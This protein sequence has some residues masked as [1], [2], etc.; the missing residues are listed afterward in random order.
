MI[1]LTA[2]G[3]TCFTLETDEHSLIFDPWLSENPEAAISPEEVSAD[4][5]L[6]SHGHSD[7][8]G[9]AIE[10]A[11]RLDVPILGA[12]ELC[13][14]CQRHGVAVEPMHIGGGRQFEF[15]HVRLTTATHGSAVI[16]D[17]LVEYTGPACGFVVSA[18][19]RVVYYA[20]DTGLFGDMALIGE[21]I[22]IDVAILPIGDN[23][24]MGPDDAVRAAQML[25]PKVVVPMHY[26]AF[27]II[28][29]DP[30]QFADR[31]AAL[32]INCTVLA[33]GEY[34]ELD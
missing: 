1:K 4:A 13:M 19:G 5:I 9:D 34:T 6:V 31:L 33:P 23:F 10:I 24:T 18:G 20:G 12:Y 8:L 2:Q 22:D 16:H 25:D 27:E 32:E 7:H 17:D 3:H 28:Q 29:Q 14:Y 11:A 26:S 30:Q 15:G 21:I